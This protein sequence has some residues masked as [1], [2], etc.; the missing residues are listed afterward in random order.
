MAL[1]TTMDTFSQYEGKTAGNDNNLQWCASSDT[2]SEILPD[3]S[4]L[5]LR[6]EKTVE[7]N[8]TLKESLGKRK[9]ED[10]CTDLHITQV[11]SARHDM[12]QT[13]GG[14]STLSL[15]KDKNAPNDVQ[16]TMEDK[17]FSCHKC[18]FVTVHKNGLLSHLGNVHSPKAKPFKCKTCDYA[19]AKNRNLWKHMRRVHGQVA[20]PKGPKC[21]ACSNT[22]CKCKVNFSCLQC[23]YRAKQKAHL[24]SHVARVHEGAKN[25]MCDECGISFWRNCSLK[26]HIK[27]THGDKSLSCDKCSY[28]TA[29][30]R[31]LKYH[32]QYV[33][34]G[35]KPYRCLYSDCDYQGTSTKAKLDEHLFAVHKHMYQCE[36]CEYKA[37]SRIDLIKHTKESHL[38][39]EQCAL[40]FDKK[41]HLTNH[42]IDLHPNI[43]PHA[44]DLCTYA[45]ADQLLLKRHQR[46]THADTKKPLVCSQCSFSTVRQDSLTK[47]VK[48]IHEGKEKPHKCTYP[49]CSTGTYTLAKLNT[50]IRRKHIEGRHHYKDESTPEWKQKLEESNVTEASNKPSKTENPKFFEN[51]TIDINSVQEE[52][53]EQLHKVDL[54]NSDMWDIGEHVVTGLL[55]TEQY[56]ILGEDDRVDLKE[57]KDNFSAACLTE[58]EIEPDVESKEDEK[59]TSSNTTGKPFKCNYCKYAGAKKRYLRKHMVKIHS[60]YMTPS[61]LNNG[62]TAHS[63]DE[64][65]EDNIEALNSFKC[66]RC[67]YSTDEK[68]LLGRHIKNVHSELKSFACDK[69][70]FKTTYKYGLA[71]HVKVVHDHYKPY[72][73]TYTGCS[74]KGTA[75]KANLDIH[76]R[77]VHLNKKDHVCDVC[78]YATVDK[79]TLL[80]HKKGV[81]ERI[82]DLVCSV[83]GYVTSYPKALQRHIKVVH[84]TKKLPSHEL[85]KDHICTACDFATH[86]QK[87][88]TD[89]IKRRHESQDDKICA[90]CGFTTNTQANLNA[91]MR[92]KHEDQFVSPVKTMVCDMCTYV[93]NRRSCLRQHVKATH[94]RIKDKICSEC[95]F[96]TSYAGALKN[97]ISEVHANEKVN[98]RCSICPYSTNRT[99]NLK[100]HI[101]TIHYKVKPKPRSKAAKN[102]LQVNLSTNSVANLNISQTS[103]PSIN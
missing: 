87:N 95:G 73:C 90:A 22:V 17:M 98:V 30:R 34:E 40:T 79:H 21:D 15:P 43:K 4:I 25:F 29:H 45:T 93:T 86:N 44:C 82:K 8:Q 53:L 24:E 49:N 100:T 20:K 50:H 6:P 42:M 5:E 71:K 65:Q 19:S 89:H 83:C 70:E 66:D 27:D 47:H 59:L 55:Y 3:T 99:R 92:R 63:A 46:L 39:C 102:T 78:G 36:N 85:V 12:Q 10:E 31:S 69:C 97:H 54:I 32:L 74:F 16:N 62:A 18:N 52:K 7:S 58:N 33:H 76:I 60:E 61:K 64:T 23:P 35:I 101:M 9:V 48:Y 80:S 28:K 72:Q 75:N 96:E 26:K 56:D 11:S 103:M 91:H 67:D 81:H 13:I 94:D 38:K 77:A 68:Y 2:K 51:S 14:S 84:E 41:T 88:L 1:E 57:E 37:L